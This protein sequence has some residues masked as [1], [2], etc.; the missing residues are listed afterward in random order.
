MYII[1][2]KIDDLS[3]FDAWNRA[4]KA[5]WDNPEGWDEEGGERGF[6]NEG[7]MYTGGWFTS[8]YGKTITILSSN[9]PS[10]KTN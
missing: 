4:L 6:Q 7:H 3:K 8:I 5:H 2:C 1:I 10:V 9:Y